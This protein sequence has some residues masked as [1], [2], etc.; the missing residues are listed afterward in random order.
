MFDSRLR[1][2]PHENNTSG[3]WLKYPDICQATVVLQ[4]AL[5]VRISK[6]YLHAEF[7]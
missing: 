7:R 3:E 6:K 4:A 5:V 2:F 1:M